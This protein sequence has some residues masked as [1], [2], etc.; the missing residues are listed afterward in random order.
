MPHPNYYVKIQKNARPAILADAFSPQKA[1]KKRH[2]NW[3]GSPSECR[4]NFVKNETLRFGKR[5][6]NRNASF[7]NRERLV[8]RIIDVLKNYSVHE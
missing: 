6:K 2:S 3:I 5:P 8:L 7:W 4:S 1:I